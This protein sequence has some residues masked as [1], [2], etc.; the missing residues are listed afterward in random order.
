MTMNVRFI[1]GALALAALVSAWYLFS[2]GG[3]PSDAIGS[4]ERATISDMLSDDDDGDGLVLSDEQYWQTDPKNPDTDGDGFLDGEE[5]LSGHDPRV[6]GPKDYLDRTQNL[7]QQT[8]DL[9]VGGLLSGE[10]LPEHPD[11][12]QTLDLFVRSL[13]EQYSSLEGT[14]LV[15]L[16]TSNDSVEAKMAYLVAFSTAFPDLLSET[17]RDISALLDSI[18]DIGVA[19]PAE[20]TDDVAR[21]TAFQQ[22]ALRVS[23]D[24]GVRISAGLAIP[25]PPSFRRQHTNIILT[26]RFLQSDLRRTATMHEDPI[27]GMVAL[28]RVIRLTVEAIPVVLHDFAIALSRKL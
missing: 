25:V 14:T 12:Q 6:A 20:L 9:L 22:E 3:T 18:R 28:Q 24:I 27:L 10:L 13:T 4:T 19:D 15:E 5:V 7:T 11:Y 23:D 21:Y 1:L 8:T 16:K 17:V 2:L 26:L